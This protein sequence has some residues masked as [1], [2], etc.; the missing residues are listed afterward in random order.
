MP[1]PPFGSLTSP[2]G[3][4]ISTVGFQL[5]VGNAICPE[6]F[7]QILNV[8]D[9]KLPLKSDMVEVTN[10]GDLYK[11]RIP[12]LLD[13]G[14][15][16]FKVY[17]VMEESSHHNGLDSTAYGLRYLWQNRLL[18]DWQAIYPDGNNSTDA[19]P[20]YVAEFNKSGLIGKAYEADI[21]LSNSGEP[22]IV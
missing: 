1:I 19:F 3:A 15:I 20:A 22:S 7:F 4:A 2:L 21:V 14:N 16:T 6:S 8:T 17:W 9:F 13:M 11:R 12:T 10:M 18:R 5:L